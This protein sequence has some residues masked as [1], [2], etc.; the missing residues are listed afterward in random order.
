MEFLYGQIFQ[1]SKQEEGIHTCFNAAT[2]STF[3]IVFKGQSKKFSMVEAYYISLKRSGRL[4]AAYKGMS[5]HGGEIVESGAWG[6][7]IYLSL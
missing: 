6:V 4:A 7:W 5:K 3:R 2:S 1:E